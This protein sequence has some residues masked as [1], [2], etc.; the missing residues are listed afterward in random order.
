[1]GGPRAWKE[2]Q[3]KQQENQS[4]WEQDYSADQIKDSNEDDL[5]MRNGKTR[6]LY[7]EYDI[8]PETD[9]EKSQRT[10]ESDDS[11]EIPGEENV[12]EFPSALC[13]TKSFRNSP[14]L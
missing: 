11:G 13:G 1:M 12:R 6:Q 7:A 2:M 8:D 3:K 5:E 10:K 14:W 9:N 4:I